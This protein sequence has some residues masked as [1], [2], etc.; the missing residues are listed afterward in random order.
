MGERTPTV[1]YTDGQPNYHPKRPYGN[2][3][4]GFLWRRVEGGFL[5]CGGGHAITDQLLAKHEGKYYA[6]PNPGFK[7]RSVVFEGS[8]HYGP[9][10]DGKSF[11]NRQGRY[12]HNDPVLGNA[13]NVGDVD[14]DAC[15][16]R[17]GC[18]YFKCL[19]I[20]VPN[21]AWEE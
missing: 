1:D 8:K 15:E 3:V 10:H 12:K 18:K 7:L 9:Y 4:D 6:D 17:G 2:C 20:T 5:C 19:H 16:G 13:R 11:A 21:H 14:C